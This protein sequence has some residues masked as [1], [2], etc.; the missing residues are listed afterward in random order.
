MRRHRIDSHRPY[1]ARVRMP[2]IVMGVKTRTLVDVCRR[3]HLI[4]ADLSRLACF[5]HAETWPTWL[6]KRDAV[7]QELRS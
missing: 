7:E 1:L 4:G 6:E 3:C 2:V 5:E